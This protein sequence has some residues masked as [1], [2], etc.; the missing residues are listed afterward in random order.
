MGLG[1]G[2]AFSSVGIMRGRGGGFASVLMQVDYQQI[3]IQS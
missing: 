3:M 2:H 1:G